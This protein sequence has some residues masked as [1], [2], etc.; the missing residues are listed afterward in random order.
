MGGTLPALFWP[1][2]MRI[3]MRLLE[4]RSRSRLRPADRPDPMAVP[5]SMTPRR[6]CSRRWRRNVIEG[7]RGG[8]VGAAGEGD[9]A[10]AV[11]GPA[12][13]R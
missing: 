12:V 9:D 11:V 10:D 8:D 2:V 1:S 4:G 6:S 13:S 3:T 5:S 7:E